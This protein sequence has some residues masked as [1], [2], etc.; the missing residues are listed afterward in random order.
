MH[1]SMSK[2]IDSVKTASALI[3]PYTRLCQTLNPSLKKNKS[4]N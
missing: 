4:H 2:I 1:R 3:V